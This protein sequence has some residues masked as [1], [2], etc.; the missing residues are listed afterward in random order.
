MA[1]KTPLQRIRV[2]IGQDRALA[3]LLPEA[4]RL[5]ELDDRL[6][7]ALPRAVAEACRVAALVD[8]E[9]LIMCANGAAASRVRG[10]ATTLA[11]ALSTD[12]QPVDR[13]KVKVRAD[14]ARPERPE[15]AGM[16]RG[17]LTAWDE[18]EHTL[19]DGDLK[20]A[21]DRLISHQRKR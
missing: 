10:T 18:L 15:K 4:Q 21:V 16:A 19:P 13:L 8:G 11:R 5:R 14:W 7:R 12:K 2:L 6:A 9:A 3:V 17:A 1:F 20:A